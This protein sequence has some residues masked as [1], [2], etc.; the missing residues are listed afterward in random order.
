MKGERN[1][2]NVQVLGNRH[3]P[4]EILHSLAGRSLLEFFLLAENKELRMENALSQ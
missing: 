4:F 1:S 3:S 2:G